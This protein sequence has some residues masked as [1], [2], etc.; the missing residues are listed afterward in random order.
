MQSQLRNVGLTQHAMFLQDQVAHEGSP[1]H[2]DDGEVMVDLALAAHEA[3][4]L[5]S[6]SAG[7]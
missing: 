1:R 5:C 4:L 3:D 7:L 6:L 2:P